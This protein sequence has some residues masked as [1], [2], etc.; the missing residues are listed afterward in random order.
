VVSVHND[1]PDFVLDGDVDR[2]LEVANPTPQVRQRLVGADEE[3]RVRFLARAWFRHYHGS[4]H[5]AKKLFVLLMKEEG[6]PFKG[7]DIQAITGRPPVET[8]T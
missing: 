1:V 4:R 8:Q 3:E 7:E 6:I 2:F 5:E